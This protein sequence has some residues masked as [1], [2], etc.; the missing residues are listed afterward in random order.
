[1]LGGDERYS[2]SVPKLKKMAEGVSGDGF[3]LTVSPAGLAR[4]RSL[5]LG[6]EKGRM[7]MPTDGEYFFFDVR[8]FEI[9]KGFPF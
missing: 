1:M 4:L 9:C 2:R 3:V 8:A 7:N 5:A 6:V